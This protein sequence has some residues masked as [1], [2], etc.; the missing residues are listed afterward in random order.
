M[1]L[2]RFLQ[3][4]EGERGLAESHALRQ[5]VQRLE[6]QLSRLEDALA[7]AIANNNA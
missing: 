6:K 1:Q 5:D 4:V 3:R 7:N 2:K